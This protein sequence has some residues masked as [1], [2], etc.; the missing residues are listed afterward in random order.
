MFNAWRVTSRHGHNK[1]LQPTLE[2]VGSLSLLANNIENGVNEL[3]T[4]GVV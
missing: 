3:G 2:T 4:L 1:K